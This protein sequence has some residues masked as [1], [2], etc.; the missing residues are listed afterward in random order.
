M[1]G[2][3][4]SGRLVP[5]ELLDMSLVRRYLW[6]CVASYGLA[7]GDRDGGAEAVHTT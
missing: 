6:V 2:E 5:V 4:A 3:I 7:A 1:M